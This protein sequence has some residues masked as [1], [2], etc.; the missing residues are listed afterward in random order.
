ML[1]VDASV[2]APSIADGGQD[3]D[4]CRARIR[5]QVL[6]A[7]DLLRLEVMSVFRR[8]LT[9]GTLTSKQAANALEDLLSLPLVIYPTAPLLRRGW[10]LRDNATAYD[11]CYVALAEALDCPLVTAGKRLVNA[12]GTRCQFEIV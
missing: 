10:E 1:V 9:N 12:P 5:G 8:Q 7:P 6:A 11:S 3:G 4:T 2:I